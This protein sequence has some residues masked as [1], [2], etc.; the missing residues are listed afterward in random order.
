MGRSVEGEDQI[1][2][3]MAPGKGEDED[4]HYP[5][6]QTRYQLVRKH[7][8][9]LRR[10]HSPFVSL[11][12]IA[13]HPATTK[14]SQFAMVPAAFACGAELDSFPVRPRPVAQQGPPHR[15]LADV[16]ER[17]ILYSLRAVTSAVVAD[18]G[19][20]PGRKRIRSKN[21]SRM[22]S[23]HPSGQ[24]TV[25]ITCHEHDASPVDGLSAIPD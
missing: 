24:P 8:N 11:R 7:G 14:R 13:Y 21:S 25:P 6:K 10:W 12:T 23:K 4:R 20:K 2:N 1:G 3:L 19:L 18:F 22:I 5:D 16:F 15:R 9:A 17:V